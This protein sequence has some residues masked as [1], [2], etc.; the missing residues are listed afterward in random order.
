MIMSD[1][2][3]WIWLDGALRPWRDAATTH[4]LHYGLGV[5]EGVRAYD[6]GNRAAIFRLGLHFTG[7][8][9]EVTP[10]IEVDR[11]RI[12]DGQPG[13]VTRRLL[14][15]FF[16]C[17]RGHDPCHADWLTPAGW[18]D[19]PAAAAGTAAAANRGGSGPG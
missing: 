10:I 5:F 19:M 14:Q 17:V 7:T 11:R 8:A 2:D 13:P 15:R 6:T 9:A 4:T 12:G 1:R 18:D 16:A 3:G